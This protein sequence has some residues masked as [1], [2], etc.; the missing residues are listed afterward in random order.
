MMYNMYHR[1]SYIDHHFETRE[2]EFEHSRD[3]VLNS[4]MQ[5]LILKFLQR[6]IMYSYSGTHSAVL[7]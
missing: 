4:V 7:I 3:Y 6:I 2:R 1:K 5:L